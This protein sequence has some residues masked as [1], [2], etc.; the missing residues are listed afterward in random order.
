MMRMSYTYPD[1]KESARDGTRGRPEAANAADDTAT[2]TANDCVLL[3][4]L[5]GHKKAEAAG[6]P[7]SKAAYTHIPHTI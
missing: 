3:F 1:V 4:H 2:R 6:A 5:F 7:A